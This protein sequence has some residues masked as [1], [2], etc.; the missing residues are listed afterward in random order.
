MTGF[1]VRYVV[2]HSSPLPQYPAMCNYSAVWAEQQDGAIGEKKN[3][4]AH[5][6]YEALHCIK[7][8]IFP[9]YLT[10]G[11]KLLENMLM[12][13]AGV[14]TA[15]GPQSSRRTQGAERAQSSELD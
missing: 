8:L 12:I 15:L 9:A 6:I 3:P 14:E 11:A 10:S 7:V 5:L 13:R 1:I 2:A 4:Q